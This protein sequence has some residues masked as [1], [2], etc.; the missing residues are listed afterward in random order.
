MHWIYIYIYFVTTDNWIK[1]LSVILASK[2]SWYRCICIY[3]IILV[4]VSVLEVFRVYMCVFSFCTG[5]WIPYSFLW[6]AFIN[7][8]FF[9]QSPLWDVSWHF[10][11]FFSG[12]A[13]V[14]AAD[15]ML[16]WRQRRELIDLVACAFGHNAFSVISRWKPW[17]LKYF[18]SLKNT[19]I[20]SPTPS[21]FWLLVIGN[22]ATN[23]FSEVDIWCGCLWQETFNSV[24]E[25]DYLFSKSDVL[26]WCLR[27]AY[28]KFM[29]W[30]KLKTLGRNNRSDWQ[31]T[32]NQGGELRDN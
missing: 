14:A 28:L 3:E 23:Q 1:V 24:T 15:E 22:D 7:K 20:H 8:E 13:L 25:E 18:F 29:L 19:H 17:K 12:K 31:G 27:D 10:T 30:W 32:R 4:G 9:W 16:K 26:Q 5:F 11:R 6:A 2:S 21:S